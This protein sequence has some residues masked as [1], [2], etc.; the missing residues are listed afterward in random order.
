LQHAEHDV[1]R[2]LEMRDAPG[3]DRRF[4]LSVTL[5]PG[6][7]STKA[8][9]VSPHFGSGFATTAPLGRRV[10]V[11]HVLDFER[12]DVLAAGDV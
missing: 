7:N 5:A 1:A 4:P 9:G 6:F 2:R 12:R 3:S 10:P 11:K 8:H